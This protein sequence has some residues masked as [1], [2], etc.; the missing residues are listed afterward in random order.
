[1][2]RSFGFD[3]TCPQ[4]DSALVWAFWQID[5]IFFAGRKFP[6]QT[7]VPVDGLADLFRVGGRQRQC[8]RPIALMGE[9]LPL[10]MYLIWVAQ[11]V[12]CTDVFNTELVGIGS[13]H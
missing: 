7:T 5:L 3:G 1:M 4:V 6:K 12:S 9:F 10:L 2:H 11:K 13:L 8:S